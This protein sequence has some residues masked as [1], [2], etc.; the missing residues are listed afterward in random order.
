MTINTRLVGIGK[1]GCSISVANIFVRRRDMD[2]TGPRKE[3]NGC[4]R[5]E[6]CLNCITGTEN[7]FLGMS[8]AHSTNFEHAASRNEKK[9]ERFVVSENVSGIMPPTRWKEQ[10]QRTAKRIILRSPSTELHADRD[11]GKWSGN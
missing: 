4:F 2:Y 6:V 11:R 3:T 9:L 10:I 1:T 8:K 5:S 7:T